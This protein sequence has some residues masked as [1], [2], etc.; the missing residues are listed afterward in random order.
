LGDSTRF[1]VAAYKVDS[2]RIAEL[3]AYEE[4]YGFDGE[5]ATIDV[6]A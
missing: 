1:V 5:K 6:I 4:R 3:Q 2:M